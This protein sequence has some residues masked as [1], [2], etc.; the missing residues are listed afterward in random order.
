MEVFSNKFNFNININ[1]QVL[2]GI[3]VL[4]P[5]S[6][7]SYSYFKKFGALPFG[8]PCQLKPSKRV[9]KICPTD[10]IDLVAVACEKLATSHQGN[11]TDEI[12]LE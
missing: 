10:E 12:W 3:K 6:V 4:N 8:D 5:P 7:K 2:K 1:Q 9:I 11:S